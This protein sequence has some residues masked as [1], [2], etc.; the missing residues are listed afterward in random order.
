MSEP[1]SRLRWKLA[2]IYKLPIDD[3]FF[4]NMNIIQLRWYAEQIY[5]DEKEE[6]ERNRDFLEYV[7]SFINPSAVEKIKQSRAS[8]ETHTFQSKEEFEKDFLA[9]EFKNNK[10]IKAIM[11]I[12][13]SKTNTNNAADDV[14]NTSGIKI[15]RDMGY[16]K[17]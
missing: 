4:N 17:D 10:Y 2:K 5:I 13:K 14:S 12:N 15:P 7:A 8:A 9:G 16:L 3:S 11:D 1:E 6:F